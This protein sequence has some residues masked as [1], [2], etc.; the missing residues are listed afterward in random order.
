MTGFHVATP[1]D[2]RRTLVDLVD[3]AELRT[4]VGAQAHEHVAASRSMAVCAPAWADV[5]RSVAELRS[6]PVALGR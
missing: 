3:D 2:V 1:A 4:S 5:L 6:S